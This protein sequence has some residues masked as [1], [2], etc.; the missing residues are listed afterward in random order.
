MS[1]SKWLKAVG[2]ITLENQLVSI[3][4]C[5]VF[6]CGLLLQATS[7]AFA[8]AQAIKPQVNSSVKQ[9]LHCGTDFSLAVE[10]CVCQYVTHAWAVS[11]SYFALCRDWRK[12]WLLGSLT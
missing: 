2:K 10:N 5:W 7:Q 12:P 3:P 4:L 11:C 6:P 8:K 1:S 9:N